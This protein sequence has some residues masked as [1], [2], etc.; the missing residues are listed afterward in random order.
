[1]TK[2]FSKDFSIQES[3][4][5][6]PY[7]SLAISAIAEYFCTVEDINQLKAA[8]SFATNNQLM[9]TPIGGGSNL[10]LV[11]D[12]SG[13]VVH[14]NLK[15]VTAD[16]VNQNQVDVHFAAGENWHE[17]VELCLN[18]GW[19]G[20]ENLALIP[21]NMGAAPIQNIG[22]YGVE[23]CDVLRSVEVIEVR[24]GEVKILSVTDCQFGYRTSVFK[25]SAKDKYIICSV[26]LRL[27]TTPKVNI[28]YPSLKAH[29]NNLEPT[30]KDIYQAVC[31]IRRSK[32]PDPSV[33]PNV[34][35]F[36]KNPVISKE[37]ADNLASS[38]PDI[39]VYSYS[40]SS[41]K[42]A[43][44]WL[45][46]RCGFKGFRKGNVGVHGNQAL[47]LVN[48]GGDGSAVLALAEKIRLAV[49]QKFAIQLEIEPRVYGKSS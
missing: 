3:I 38:Y 48:Y 36:F 42:L 47:V 4:D 6:K 9:I 20:L 13:L 18:N 7:N 37:M 12:I 8:L 23:L 5:L 45:I 29:I 46:E 28:K 31:D 22:A 49:S 1:M 2:A 34:G 41:S 24:T 40:E 43:A 33:I 39:P 30:P 21:G 11:S 25:Q 15:G 44:A 10:V 27:S 19:Y 17:M 16:S 14:I 26:C 35:S 32:L